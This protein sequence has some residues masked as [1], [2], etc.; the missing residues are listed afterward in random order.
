MSIAS[1]ICFV[2]TSLKSKWLDYQQKNISK[3]FPESKRI[4]V[5]GS[6][7]WPR[8]WFY[9]IAQVADL[10]DQYKYYIHIDDDCFLLS[11]ERLLEVVSLFEEGK[12][13]LCGPPDGTHKYRGANPVAMNSFL[14]MGRV[15]DIKK[16][17]SSGRY[18]LKTLQFG[19]HPVNGWLNST[20]LKFK[21]EY[22]VGWKPICDEGGMTFAQDYEPYYLFMWWMK[23][24]GVR[25]SYLYPSFDERFKSTNPRLTK[26]SEDIA[27]HMWYSRVW[28]SPMD[29][30]GM[31]NID[32]FNKLEKFLIK[33]H[34]I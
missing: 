20:G 32:R 24:M 34:L 13:D 25:F 31:K 28:N 2:T 22:K 33:N 6:N 5:D 10:S 4:V 21:E 29:V 18:N 14:M 23:E 17:V 12:C 1:S 8:A 3:I 27:I 11:R 16:L 15:D 9:W 30:H 26:D 7:D 19:Y